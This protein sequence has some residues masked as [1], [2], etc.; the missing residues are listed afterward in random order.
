MKKIL[1]TQKPASVGINK[2]CQVPQISAVK[3][4]HKNDIKLV[5]HCSMECIGHFA[6]KA[7]MVKNWLFLHKSLSTRAVAS[8]HTGTFL[9]LAFAFNLLETV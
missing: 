9:S 3:L 5:L 4:H 2:K 8:W 1:T 7:R 6:L